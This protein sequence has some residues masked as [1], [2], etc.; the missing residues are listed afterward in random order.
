MKNNRGWVVWSLSRIGVM[1]AVLA[2]LL[3]TYAIYEYVTCV[4][5]SDSANQEAEGLAE[6]MARIYAGPVGMETTYLL[7]SK[8]EG[9]E[10]NA[11]VI[12]ESRK[13]L[14]VNVPGTRCGTC[15]GGAPFNVRLGSYPAP[16]KNTAETNV[17]L[18]VKN[19]ENGVNIRKIDECCNCLKIEEFQYEAGDDCNNLNGEYVSFK[20]AC[21]HPCDITAWTVEDKIE[22]RKPY[23]FPPRTIDADA[24]VTL[25]T[26]CGTD[27]TANAYWCSS[28]YPCNAI[29]NNDGDTLTLRES[30]G[31]KCLE[32]V[33]FGE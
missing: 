16:L 13:G 5:A 11:S 20:N 10:Y 19:L 23:K 24:S 15:S 25:R 27:T 6:T 17:T 30:G 12:N 32:Y 8:I 3:M 26:G 2:I 14:L 29:W 18:V 7:P 33:Y 1:I 31:F 28:G 22:A 4:A 21:D 9:H